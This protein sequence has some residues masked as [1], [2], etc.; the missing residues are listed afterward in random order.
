M[1][2]KLSINDIVD[3]FNGK[4]QYFNAA[5]PLAWVSHFMLE[6]FTEGISDYANCIDWEVFSSIDAVMAIHS[7]LVN[8]VFF[9]QPMKELQ[10][11]FREKVRSVL[12]FRNLSF[13]M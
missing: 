10:I 12:L 6:L 8:E 7:K 11:L 3:I 9:W 5:N 2:Q 4:K 1:S 13:S